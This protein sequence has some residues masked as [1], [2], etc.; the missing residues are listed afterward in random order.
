MQEN[1]GNGNINGKDIINVVVTSVGGLFHPLKYLQHG[2]KSF[3][4]E[5]L[6]RPVR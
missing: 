6:L 3:Q 2:Y 1:S 4:G 5:T